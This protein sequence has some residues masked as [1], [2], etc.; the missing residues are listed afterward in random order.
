MK[1]II[2]YMDKPIFIVSVLL[3]VIGLIMVFSSSNVTAYMTHAVSPYNYFIKQGIFL[4]VGSIL[5]IV[6]VNFNTKA[7][8]LFSHLLLIVIG[9]CLLLLLLIGKSKNQA[10]SWFDF[11]PFSFQPS[12]FAKII[13]IVW[14]STYYEKNK[15]KLKSYFVSLFPLVVCILVALLIFMQPDLGTTVIYLLIVGLMF[16]AQ[17]IPSEI[18]RRVIFI[19]VGIIVLGLLVLSFSGK[20]LIFERQLERLNISNPCDRLLETGNQVCNGYIAINNGG[21]TGKGLGNSTQKYLY[22]PEP[23][24]DFIFTITV[25]E[26]GA[27]VG[28]IIILLYLFILYRI[29]KIG[30]SSYNNRN[31]AMCYGVFVYLFCHI[32]INLLGIFGLI[33]MTGVPLPFMSYG[34]SFTICLVAALTLVQRVSVETGI[35][36]DMKNE[37]I[38]KKLN[39]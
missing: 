15:H 30:K 28:C 39:R 10:I 11:G 17:P 27:G 37:G 29:L 16:L 19:A 4:L 26:L 6:M 22:L 18:K 7:Y 9:V 3:F 31:S 13:S 34:G 32:A 2:R 12:E 36:T 38:L 1:K 14:I 5:A 24:T 25:E 35:Q 23:Y 20:E 21:L 33:P 8:G